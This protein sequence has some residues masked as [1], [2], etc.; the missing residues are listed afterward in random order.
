MSRPTPAFLLLALL[1]GCRSAATVPPPAP[2]TSASPADRL[3]DSIKWVR[4]SAEY[5]AAFEQTYRTATARVEIGASQ[6]PAGSWAVVLDADETVLNN[7][8]YQEERARAGLSFSPASWD[9]WV[10]RREATALPAAAAF[11]S[12]VRTLGGR[13]AVV[14]NRLESQCADT[15]AV[16]TTRV[17][18][19]DAILCQPDGEPPDK[20]PR[21]RVV[22]SGAAFGLNQ[23]VAVIAYIGDNI[24]DFPGLSQSI[25]TGRPEGFSEFGVR[26]FIL[27]NPMYGSWQ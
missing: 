10:K 6:H 27:P 26:F 5:V 7:A 1:S 2:A 8:Q 13:I 24:L 3:P 19:Y 23:P 9:A 4:G 11:L 14:T 22:E 15:R 20:N 16:F 17:L 18:A 12:R 25:R 21:F